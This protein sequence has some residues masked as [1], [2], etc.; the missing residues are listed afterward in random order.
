MFNKFYEVILKTCIRCNT[1]TSNYLLKKASKAKTTKEFNDYM[2]SFNTSQD[3]L[4]SNYDELKRMNKR[5]VNNCR[6]KYER[7][8][9]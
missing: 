8:E 7:G 2:K 1:L 6:I 4:M 5:R 9:A 3:M